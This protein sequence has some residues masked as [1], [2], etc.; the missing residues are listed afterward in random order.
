MKLSDLKPNQKG[1]IT[2]IMGSFE[3]KRRL[4]SMGIIEG[5]EIRIVR[6]APL[7]DPI[8]FEVKGYH[9][10]LR[11]DEAENVVVEVRE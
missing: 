7:N 1:I 5:A 10:S 6:N 3:I 4:L 9:L 2:K 11:R 8:E